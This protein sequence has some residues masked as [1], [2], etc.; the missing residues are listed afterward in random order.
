MEGIDFKILPVTTEDIIKPI[1]IGTKCRWYRRP[2]W[3]DN[4]HAPT[5]INP[6]RKYSPSIEKA[7]KFLLF[8]F[9]I[10]IRINDNP[11]ATLVDYHFQ[12]YL[13]A[14]QMAAT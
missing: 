2:G 10:P 14:S 1:T 9:S 8:L 7:G 11:K 13:K 4:I 12:I 3:R 5:Q 6:F